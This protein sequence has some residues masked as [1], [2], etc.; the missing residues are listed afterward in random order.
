MNDHKLF[1]GK[2]NHHET[3]NLALITLLMLGLT[4]IFYD[5]FKQGENALLINNI[6]FEEKEIIL[7]YYSPIN[8]IKSRSIPQNNENTLDIELM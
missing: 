3:F 6:N 5:E 7:N 1:K 2:L 4:A 8:N